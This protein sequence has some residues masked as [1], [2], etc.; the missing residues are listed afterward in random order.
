M[1]TLAV[2]DAVQRRAAYTADVLAQADAQAHVYLDSRRRGQ[3]VT[4]EQ[5]EVI[6]GIIATDYDGRTV[7]ELLQNGHD[8]HEAAR[9][10]GALEIVLREDEGAHGVLYV[11]NGGR[12]VTRADFLSLCRLGMSSKL[13]HEG[14]GNKGAGFKSVLQ[15]C[16]AP[17]IYSMA[18]AAGTAFDGYCLRFAQPSDFD[19]LAARIAPEEPG[20]ADALRENVAG[21]KVPVPLHEVP[22]R[23]AEFGARG[24]VT[25][26]RLAL[27]SATACVR[28]RSQLDE[29]ASSDV[30]LQLFLDRLEHILLSRVT[31]QGAPTHTNLTRRTTPRAGTADVQIEEL[32]LQD[33]ARF[34]VLRRAVPES[35]MR[36]AITASRVEGRLSARWEG[37][38]GDGQVSIAVPVDAPLEA[39]RLYTFLPMGATAPLPAFVNAPFFARLDRLSFEEAVPLND[40]LL[41]EVAHLCADAAL[42]AVEGEIDIDAERLLDLVTWVPD[43]LPRLREALTDR[44]TALEDLA[45][46]PKLASPA[47]RTTLRRGR[48]WRSNG[49]AFNAAAVV[50][51]GVEDLVEPALHR[52]RA[53]RL[54]ALAG[55]LGLRLTPSDEE[56]AGFA[57]AYAKRLAES[58]SAMS[59]WADFF[60]DLAVT[61]GRG[62]ALAG[63][64]V[65]LDEHGELLAAN[66]GKDRGLVVFVSRRE[67][68]ADTTTGD[69]PRV[70]RSRLAFTHPEIPRRTTTRGPLRPGWKWLETEG[71][72]REYRTDAVLALVGEAMQGADDA[73]EE[74]LDGCLRFAFEIWRGASRDIGD[75][76]LARAGLRVPAA[77][78]WVPAA[79]AVFGSGWGGATAEVDRLLIEL[80]GRTRGVSA[81]MSRLAERV[82]LTPEHVLGHPDDP[83]AAREFLERLGVGHGLVPGELPLPALRLQG[84]Q[85]ASPTSVGALP[86]GVPKVTQDGWRT[87]AARWPD[88]VPQYPSTD[89]R[90]TLPIAVVPGQWD[91]ASFDDPARR[92]Y[93]ELVLHGLE[94]WPDTALE[95]R[96]TRHTD[97]RGAAWPSL[98]AWFLATAE[99]V[100][101]TKPGDRAT[102]TQ[103]CPSE[104][105]WL[106]D[107]ETPDY[108]RAQPAAL[109]RLA[110]P[111][112]IARLARLGVRFWDEPA[113]ALARL[114][115]L[116][117]I[118]ESE[119]RI[120]GAIG[121]RKAWE[122][123]WHD[124]LQRNP[125][126]QPPRH[127]I[128]SQHGK[129]SVIDPFCDGE[130]V[131]VP[132]AAGTATERLLD[133]APVLM[134]PVR[135]PALA[136]RVQ[137]R[138]EV[139]GATRLKAASS[140]DVRVTAGDVAA[141]D[142]AHVPLDELG[143]RW[144]PALVVGIME[145]GDRSFPRA[146]SADLFRAAR[147]LADAT[148]AVAAEVA[149]WIDGH[150]V[151][152]QGASASFLLETRSGS[153]I[154]V[155]ARSDATRW[156]VLEAAA[157]ALAELVGRPATADTLRLRLIELQRRCGTCDPEA[158]DVAAVL[159]VRLEDVAGLINAR[160]DVSDVVAVLACIDITLA[161]ELHGADA[162]PEGRDAMRAWLDERL[163]SLPP[164]AE[165]VLELADRGDL[166]ATIHELGV[167]FAAATA[168]LR[169][170]GLTPPAN[171]AGHAHQLQTYVQQHR[172]DLH[173]RLRDRF[174]A[175]ARRGEPLDT[176]Q[177][178]RDFA[179]LVEDPAWIN[180]HWDLTEDVIEARVAAWLA[181]VSPTGDAPAIALP[182]VDELREAGRRPITGV[183]GYVPALVDA[184]LHRHAAGDGKRP[185]ALA[186][187]TAAM[188]ESGRLDFGPLTSA[189]VVGWLDDHG[190]WPDGMKRTSSRTELELSED[191]I[192]AARQRLSAERDDRRRQTTHVTYAGRAYSE[193]LADLRELAEAIRADVRS[194]VLD[195]PPEPRPLADLDL[196]TEPPRARGSG[197][198]GTSGPPPEKASALGLAGEIVVGEWIRHRFGVPPED[199]WMSGYRLD[200]LA[201]GIGSDGLGYDFRVLTD[202]RTLLFESRRRAG[203]TPSSSSVRRRCAGPK[204]SK[205]ARSTSSSLSPTSLIRT[206]DA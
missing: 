191:D 113:S 14:I 13:P 66:D 74:L 94:R 41:C 196:A 6:E 33:G 199:S 92:I 95:F 88:H 62:E 24:L 5:K 130:S 149:T 55:H 172:A 187:V 190:Q 12:P 189:N 135:Q 168:A 180:E 141:E 10:D 193:E 57:E 73:D 64:R 85:V 71:L 159:G 170:L 108:I 29:L 163:A 60:D 79:T 70:V 102:V 186:G 116:A 153:R 28:A 82:L 138:L 76:A 178:A 104:A 26:V 112:V 148:V 161:E 195:T 151:R 99:W 162:Q 206:H 144:L 65:L 132:D 203:K 128:A 31:S 136:K 67:E 131:Y 126:A 188:I 11:A 106:R 61:L 81:S 56:I 157:G 80:L 201:D 53:D 120:P 105:W 169:T 17:E 83:D 118:V 175:V 114:D 58:G 121:I 156:E 68:D 155:A 72:V 122:G 177:R 86:I 49:T 194:A 16:D 160:A 154:V 36:A 19:D 185:G 167:S 143:A 4:R 75:Q 198:R 23:V 115:E 107:D 133:Q 173:D 9:S 77:V 129:L 145:Y 48:M 45:V 204:H 98:A 47:G 90:A 51:A 150:E 39:G 137:Q 142:A 146:T 152:E 63:R 40:L 200:Q 21:L 125:S 43:G 87:L 103:R 140:A 202:E 165:E 91:W 46:L 50:D 197:G 182:P 184:W 38:K 89:Y 192:A 30:P 100:P 3:P 15:L 139:A 7:V 18:A 37:W 110:T 34:T 158:G 25:V 22:G 183:L 20:L 32:T 111:K 54:L 101:Q 123:A 166:V 35:A 52:I 97:P 1:S 109:R 147:S 27:R 205:L 2:P 171:P 69:P 117:G 127:I 124:L 84:W 174:A 181:D 134:L 176:Y 164:S 59:A 44:G 119:A 8:A 93:A 179:G 78:G 42:R 96:F